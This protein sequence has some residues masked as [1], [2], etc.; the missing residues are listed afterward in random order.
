[1]QQYLDIKNKQSFLSARKAGQAVKEYLSSTDKKYIIL[2]KGS[3]NT[4]FSEEAVKEILAHSDD[5]KQLVRQDQSWIKKKKK[6]FFADGSRVRKKFCFADGSRVRKNC[7]ADSPVR[8]KFFVA[9]G[10]QVKKNFYFR[11]QPGEK[12]T[13]CGR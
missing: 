13:F 8:K 10:S 9:D 11:W 5:M 12:E 4:I 2:V 6:F 3:Q 1:M 7:F